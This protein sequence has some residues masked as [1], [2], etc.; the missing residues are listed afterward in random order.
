MHERKVVVLVQPL[1]PMPHRL[2]AEATRARPALRSLRSG[3]ALLVV[4]HVGEHRREVHQA[5]GAPREAKARH[6]EWLVGELARLAA[7]GGKQ[8]YL[9]A[10]FRVLVGLYFVRLAVREEAERAVVA[11]AGC[12]VFRIAARELHRRAAVGRKLPQIANVLGAVAIQPI[13]ANREPFAV[14]RCGDGRD[15]AERD[16]LLDRVAHR[17]LITSRSAW[18][19][20]TLA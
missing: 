15:A 20:S 6:A 4:R 16:V 2:G 19:R 10:S 17:P 3:L 14:E 11:E 8:P 18:N 13:D 9:H 7:V 1:V 12:L 5:I